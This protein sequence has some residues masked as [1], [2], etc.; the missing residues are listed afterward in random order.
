MKSFS[1]GGIYRITGLYHAETA[2]DILQT[3]SPVRLGCSGYALAIIEVMD[4]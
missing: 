3:H 4:L 2:F 1:F